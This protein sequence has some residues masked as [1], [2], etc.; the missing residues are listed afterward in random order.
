MPTFTYTNFDCYVSQTFYIIKSERINHKYLTSLLNS[1]L[2]AFWLKHK[3][4]MQGS[5]Y[6]I[7]KA[8][9]LELPII[10]PSNTIVFQKLVDYIILQKSLNAD[11]SF[12]ERLIDAMVYE[13]YFPN[14]MKA[15]NCEVLKHL[16]NLPE[17][18]EDGSNEQKLKTIEQGYKQLSDPHHPISSALLRMMNIEEIEIIEGRK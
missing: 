13:L 10:K 4:K 5:Q 9:L 15:A 7:D 6:Q 3:G 11:S 1:K 12:F 2:I 17:L 16:D 14:E 8:P 18:K